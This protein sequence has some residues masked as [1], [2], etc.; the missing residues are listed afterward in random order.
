MN[1]QPWPHVQSMLLAT[2]DVGMSILLN[3]SLANTVHRND[4]FGNVDDLTGFT[5]CYGSMHK[6]IHGEMGLTELI[7]QQGYEVD[8]LLA[9][10][11]AETPTTYCAANGNPEDILY[12]GHYFGTNVHP[13][14]LV[15]IKANRNIDPTLLDK[16][17]S[18]HLSQ[19]TSAW[20][21]CGALST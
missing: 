19:N 10:F 13:Y 1:C 2:D 12:E 18:W 4:F 20:D 11:Q 3:P 15:F 16:M 9:A 5:P 17:T 14:E 8:V 6:A 7:R 21:T